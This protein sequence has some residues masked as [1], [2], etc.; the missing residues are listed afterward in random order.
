MREDVC[1]RLTTCGIGRPVSFSRSIGGQGRGARQGA[2]STEK[3]VAMAGLTF[4]LEQAL[5]IKVA[6]HHPN[7]HAHVNTDGRLFA[8]HTS[9][10]PA[11]TMT[12][13]SF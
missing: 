6:H 3:K 9:S 11:V 7:T 4:T 5:V 10:S 2:L 1:S 12:P 13:F 8:L